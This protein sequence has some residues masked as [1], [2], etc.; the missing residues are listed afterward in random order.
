MEIVFFVTLLL[1]ALLLGYAK[2]NGL[3]NGLFLLY[4]KAYRQYRKEVIGGGKSYQRFVTDF[5]N[6]NLFLPVANDSKAVARLNESNKNFHIVMEFLQTRSDLVTSYF[7]L[8]HFTFEDFKKLDKDF[9]APPVLAEEQ[10]L[11]I[12]EEK[13]I[14]RTTNEV[15]DLS[16][17]EENERVEEKVETYIP[18]AE[19]VNPFESTLTDGQIEYLVDCIN[20][21]K[22]FNTSV[23]PEEL[24]AIFICKPKTIL[25]SNNNRLIAFFFSG[26]SDRSLITLNWQ[27]VIANY[28]LFLSKDKNR[29]KYINQSDLSSATNHIRDIGAD[30]KYA[31]IDNYLKQVKKH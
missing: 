7:G 1:I 30:G 17:D 5:Y 6:A 12:V 16:V 2:V 24:K 8:A 18:I 19:T 9:N 29:E 20:E 3:D 15:V 27:S 13:I 21:V 4:R 11:S 31:I 22:M 25:R 14:E 23:T 28:H 26:L 10:E